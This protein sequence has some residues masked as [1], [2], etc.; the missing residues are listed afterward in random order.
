MNTKQAN[1]MTIICGAVLLYDGK[2]FAGM[3]RGISKAFL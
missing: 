1:N 3:A 2:H